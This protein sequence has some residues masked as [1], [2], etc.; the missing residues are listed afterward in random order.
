VTAVADF[1]TV[2]LATLADVPAITSLIGRSVRALSAG[3]YTPA[4]V[5][6]ALKYVFGVDTQLVRDGTYYVIE[7]P[8]G[9]LAAAGGWSR[10][11]TLY[12]G[13]QAK[14]A[15]DPALDPS[16]DPARIRAFFVD[17]A[18]AR[19]GLGRRLFEACAAAAAAAGFRA[20][21]LAATL[22]GEPFYRALGFAP[23][24][25]VVTTL[26]DGQALAVNRMSRPLPGVQPPVE[27]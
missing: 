27:C 18:F 12:G 16:V 17:P 23:I 7:S 11:T 9:G 15:A 6:S 22:P 3:Y 4:Q 19:R 20:L 13:D 2:R 25:R 5:E 1:P 10:R 14:A 21:E 24:E 8:G 26:P